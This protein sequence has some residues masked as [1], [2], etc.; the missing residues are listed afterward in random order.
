[1]EEPKEEPQDQQPEPPEI[2]LSTEP[3]KK[4]KTLL[5]ALLSVFSLLLIAAGV[6]FLFFFNKPAS[7]PQS[8][9]SSSEPSSESKP[10]LSEGS[11][12]DFDL[13]LLKFNEKEENIVY[14]PLS[15]KYALAMLKDGAS[16]DSK[17]QIE[18]VLGDYKPKAYLNSENRS[19]AN[20]I[21]INNDFK[22]QVLPT[23]IDLLNKNYYADVAYDSFSTPDKVNNWISDKTLNIINKMFDESVVNPELKFLLVN[24][25]AIDMN[26]ENQLICAP[27]PDTK[28]EIGC[29]YYTVNPAHENYSDYVPKV[30]D[31]DSFPTFTFNG[32]ENTKSAKIAATANRYDIIKVLG[33]DYIRKTV[34]EEYEKWVA[35]KKA[36]PDYQKYPDLY[37]LDFDLDEYIK[38][39]DEN[40]GKYSDSTD[41]LFADTETERVFAKDLK[42][43][44]GATLEYVGIMPKT[45]ALAN[46]VKDLDAKKLSSLISD[47]KTP[48]LET[49]KDGVVTKLN[50]NIPFF[51]YNFSVD[52]ANY[53]KSLNIT[54]VFN[55]ETADLSNMLKDVDLASKNRPFINVATHKADI[56]FSND[57]IKAAA[58]TALGGMGAAFSESFEYKWDV[59]VEEIDLT[60]NKP[61]LFLILDKSTR[62][63][64]FIGSVYKI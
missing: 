45:E 2:P 9:Q 54:D 42:E 55:P 20:A 52:L 17:A 60:F 44:D 38:E 57:G 15:L 61:F 62:E 30:W 43:Y 6:Y 64:W 7:S 58:V 59:P 46:Y 12:S 34:T 25:L 19:L 10:E 32:K 56:D 14:S 5:I 37:N 41:F 40:Y 13:S 35:E 22:D 48:A 29:K 8:S 50:A 33:E 26:W 31:E 21:F 11:L 27:N 28:V 47:L 1:M 39:L 16:G 23:Y 63:V 3:K 24:A 51:K 4:P 36:D 53:L 18:A 49:F